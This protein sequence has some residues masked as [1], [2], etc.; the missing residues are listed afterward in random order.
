MTELIE[1]EQQV[2]QVLST[3]RDAAVE[4]L[5]DT[6]ASEAVMVFP[7]GM[8]LS[9]RD[10]IL[11]AIDAQPWSAFELSGVQQIPLSDDARALIYQVHAHRGGEDPYRALISS[12][13]I[14]EAGDWKLAL[15]QQTPV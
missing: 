5:A 7:G 4:H 10:A 15:H 9:G 8:R 11:D 3:S 13:W 1:R 2:W 14:H 6:L 12:V